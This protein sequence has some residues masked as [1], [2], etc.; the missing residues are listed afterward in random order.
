MTRKITRSEET[1]K[2]DDKW[3]IKEGPKDK[4]I[5]SSDPLKKS[6]SERPS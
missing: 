4:P 5:N 2:E 1:K 6:Y 3:L